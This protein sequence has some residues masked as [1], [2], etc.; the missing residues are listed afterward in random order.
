MNGRFLLDTNA[1]IALLG[2][3]PTLASDLNTASWVGISI[4]SELEFLSFR[5]LTNTDRLLFEQFKNRIEVINLDTSDSVLINEV[6]TVRQSYNLKLPD[7]IIAA[8]ALTQSATVV[9]N[10][11]AFNKIPSLSIKVY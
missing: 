5:N 6:T 11:A 10:D 4:I 8:T 3:H 7:A 1:V 2:S 9:T